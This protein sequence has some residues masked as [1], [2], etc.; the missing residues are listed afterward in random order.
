MGML[1]EL[2]PDYA[3][4]PIKGISD[5]HRLIIEERE[6]DAL[7]MFGYTLSEDE[8]ARREGMSHALRIAKEKGVDGLEKDLKMRGCLNIPV[9]ISKK[10]VRMLQDTIQ[11]KM[12]EYLVVLMAMV[13][14][15][16]FDFGQKRCQR[17]IDR[18][19]LKSSCIA[20]DYEAWQEN[21]DIL[22]T[23]CGIDLSLIFED[24][25]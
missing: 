15:D 3:T 22:K 24:I 25:K 10:Q 16:E 13:L 9:G 6:A 11:E 23:E 20:D 5:T 2:H 21:I 8:Q 17:A 19:M 14:H 1:S 4:K 12:A 7:G 18:F